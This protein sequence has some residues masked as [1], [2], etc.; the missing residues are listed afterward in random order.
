MWQHW[1]WLDKSHHRTLNDPL[2][3][4]SFQAV[5]LPS[6]WLLSSSRFLKYSSLM[7]TRKGGGG[8]QRGKVPLEVYWCH[9]VAT[10]F[11]CRRQYWAK[12]LI[13]SYTMVADAWHSKVQSVSDVGLAWGSFP[14]LQTRLMST[15]FLL[16]HKFRDI[17]RQLVRWIIKEA[18]PRMNFFVH[19]SKGKRLFKCFTCH[20]VDYCCCVWC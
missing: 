9:L 17:L 7:T 18:G 11:T 15:V 13:F 1:I 14:I 6:F 5:S 3:R 2:S 4:E 8:I 12:Y 20:S 19:Q 10:V 16:M